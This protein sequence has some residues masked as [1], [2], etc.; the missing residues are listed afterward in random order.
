MEW[1]IFMTFGFINGFRTFILA[2]II[3]GAT[4]TAQSV[5]TKAVSENAYSLV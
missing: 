3:L 5:K 1:V 2:P 4:R